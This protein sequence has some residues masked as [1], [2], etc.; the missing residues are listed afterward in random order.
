MTRRGDV[1][2]IEFPYVDGNRGK[3][4]PALVVQQHVGCVETH[5]FHCLAPWQV[6]QWYTIGANRLESADD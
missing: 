5:R 3:N 1:I 6:L 2:I 4:R